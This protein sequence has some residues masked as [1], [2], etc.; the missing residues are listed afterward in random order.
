MTQL[1]RRQVRRICTERGEVWLDRSVPRANPTVALH[2][3]FAFASCLASC[4]GRT[5]TFLEGV[6]AAV[7]PSLDASAADD[8]GVSQDAGLPVDTGAQADTGGLPSPR[9]AVLTGEGTLAG[10]SGPD[11][12]Q[13]IFYPEEGLPPA[14]ALIGADGECS[15]VTC[16]L[17]PALPPSDNAGTVVASVGSASTVIPY[18]GTS[19]T[20]TYSGVNID[21]I[22]TTGDTMEFRGPGGPD[23]PAFD[24]SVTAPNL[25]VLDPPW[26]TTEVTID[27]TRDLSLSWGA[28][29]TGDAVFSVT[30][31]S[32]HALICYFDARPGGAVVPQENLAAFKDLVGDAGTNAE[33][34]VATRVTVAVVGWQLLANAITWSGADV[35]QY[36]AVIL[37]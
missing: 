12:A 36:G 35:S 6:P 22:F 5:A 7:A 23:V 9:L 37:E 11:T 13:V 10:L 4:G 29:P 27:T 15:V 24:V 20:G 33:F 31:A 32:G 21:A 19:P 3:T 8:A 30:D 26:F 14:C 34:F 25:V 18:S 2:V 16:P 28:A 17:T 1:F